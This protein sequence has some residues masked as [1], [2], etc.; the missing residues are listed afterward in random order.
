M[1]EITE[2]DASKLMP[3][4]AETLIRWRNHTNEHIV[5]GFTMQGLLDLY[6]A[7][8]EYVCLEGWFECD[9]EAM[10][11]YEAVKRKPTRYQKCQ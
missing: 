3:E 10:F 4:D 8:S 5:F 1:A 2:T 6:H 7:S 9:D 11:K